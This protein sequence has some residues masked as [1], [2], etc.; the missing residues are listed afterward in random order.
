MK[1]EI[2][3][4]LLAKAV[5]ERASEDQKLRN[6]INKF[7]KG[8]FELYKQSGMILSREDL[9][10]I[11]PHLENL[12]L[13]EEQEAFLSI[14]K[15]RLKL[16]FIFAS[17][18][19]FLVLALFLSSI[20]IWNSSNFISIKKYKE[21]QLDNLKLTT[22]LLKMEK[23][24]ESLSLDIAQVKRLKG[25]RI[26]KLKY[27]TNKGILLKLKGK[28]FNM[29]HSGE[30]KEDYRE[31]TNGW[32]SRLFGVS[33]I[34]ENEEKAK[35]EDVYNWMKENSKEF[36][37]KYKPKPFEHIQLDHAYA[38]DRPQCKSKFIS[39]EIR[40]GKKRWG[41]K[42]GRIYFC[43]MGGEIYDCKNIKN[44]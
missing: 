27:K 26:Q 43:V 14:S 41:A 7:I 16:K 23:T 31:L 17:T 28:W 22:T 12:N 3:H 35:P 20:S 42:K 33:L 10:F 8:K 5:H 32:L 13:S 1:L 38:S 4:D 29:W 18:F 24:T 15:N 21:L 37:S 40:E 39:I 9:A 11:H 44:N 2:S 36:L 30:K 34:C 25:M 6:K 19:A